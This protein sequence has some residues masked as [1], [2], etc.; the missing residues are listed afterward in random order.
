LATIL[1]VTATG[2]GSSRVMHRAIDRLTVDEAS[3]AAG[4]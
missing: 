2:L 4:R 1:R 3:L